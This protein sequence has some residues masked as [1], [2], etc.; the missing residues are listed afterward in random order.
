LADRRSPSWDAIA[1]RDTHQPTPKE[2]KPESARRC[3]AL[4]DLHGMPPEIVTG[5][6]ELKPFMY[7]HLD[8]NIV[9]VDGGKEG[10]RAGPAVVPQ[11][12][13]THGQNAK[14]DRHVYASRSRFI[15]DRLLGLFEKTTWPPAV[16]GAA[17]RA[18]SQGPRIEVGARMR[19]MWR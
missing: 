1:S 3:R 18:A 19:G 9:I 10:R 13:F 2:F 6:P 14:G 5:E 12:F 15:P 7:A 17:S 8:H 16:A 11:R 4:V